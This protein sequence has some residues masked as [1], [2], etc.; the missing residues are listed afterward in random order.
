MATILGRRCKDSRCNRLI[1][2]SEKDRCFLNVDDNQP[3]REICSWRPYQHVQDAAKD[4]FQISSTY[5]EEAMKNID[6]QFSSTQ[7]Q[8]TKQQSL[9]IELKAKVDYLVRGS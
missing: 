4:T 6:S 8:I 7:C 3:H 9:L 2:Y 5:F 1:Y